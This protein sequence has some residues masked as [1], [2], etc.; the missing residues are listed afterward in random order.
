MMNF[1][2]G[3]VVQIHVCRLVLIVNLNLS[4]KIHVYD[5]WQT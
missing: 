1:K 4:I 2:L 5:K 3:L